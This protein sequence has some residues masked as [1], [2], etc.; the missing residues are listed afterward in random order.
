M[1]IYFK[2]KYPTIQEFTAKSFLKKYNGQVRLEKN[3]NQPPAECTTNLNRGWPLM[4]GPAIDDKVQWHYLKALDMLVTEL[5][6]H[7]QMWKSL[8]RS[9]N[10]SLKKT[11][12]APMWGCNI[13]QRL[14]F[15]R[16]FE[17]NGKVEVL[18][19]VKKEVGLQHHFRIINI[20][21]N[22]NIPKSLEL[23]LL[24][25]VTIKICYCWLYHNGTKKSTLCWFSWE[26]RQAQ[27]YIDFDSHTRWK[28]ITIPD[29]LWRQN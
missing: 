4:V 27:D 3:L 9:E 5:Y 24:W 25:P 10:L 18:K 21:E 7:P 26:Y 8:S 2:R 20:I 23:T 14:E 15:R 29:S 12:T 28:N 16:R 6:Q 22:N 13:I 17:T 1:A 11:E 19:E